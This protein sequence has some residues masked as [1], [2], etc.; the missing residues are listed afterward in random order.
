MRYRALSGLTVH[1]RPVLVKHQVYTSDELAQV[2][3]N[4]LCE[5]GVLV[6]VGDKSPAVNAED[7]QPAQEETTSPPVVEESTPKDDKKPKGK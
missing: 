3:A 1:G 7:P 5:S 2:L 4:G 6:K